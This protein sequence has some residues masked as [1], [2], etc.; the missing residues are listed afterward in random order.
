MM[1][2]C[3]VVALMSLMVELSL[4]SCPP[5]VCQNIKKP[6][7][8]CKG[9]III[10]GGYCGCYDLCTSVEGEPCGSQPCELGL[11]C[12]DTN[13]SPTSVGVCKKLHP[14]VDLGYHPHGKRETGHTKTHCEQMRLSSMI[15]MVV[16]E[17]QWFAKCDSLGNFMPMQCDNTGH[18]FCVDTLSGA[19]QEGSK[20]LGH[21]SCS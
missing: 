1:R 5:N 7:L 20:V 6:V 16:Y 19:V 15:S 2:V 8:N 21:A 17:G 9:G 14:D 11:Q 3:V 12:V 4:A 10:G 18:C 13:N